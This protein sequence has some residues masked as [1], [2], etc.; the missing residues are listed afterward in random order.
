MFVYNFTTLTAIPDESS[1]GIVTSVNVPEIG[2][3]NSATLTLQVQ[4]QTG[5]SAFLGDLY[6]T[7]LHESQS[8]VLL[9]RP[10]RRLGEP[11]GYS[12]NRSMGVTFTD[13]ATANIH[14]Y[15]LTLNGDHSTPLAGNLSGNWK[16]DGR[17]TDPDFVLTTDASTSLLANFI[18]TPSQGTW[19]VFL[20]DLSTGGAHEVQSW[21][22]LLD[23]T[24]VPEPG[25]WVCL[26]GFGLL[27]WGFL[28]RY[29]G[30]RY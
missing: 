11:A 15:R 25:T 7:L 19:S 22:L 10:G 27:S 21:S 18:G 1:S 20:A 30:A 6:G 9:N 2:I 17:I 3:V 8:S 24:P 16:P 4:A 14:D 23:I 29:F 5:Q 13:A 28:R 26:T 12:D